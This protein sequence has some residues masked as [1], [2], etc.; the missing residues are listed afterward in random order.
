MLH[1]PLSAAEPRNHRTLYSLQVQYSPSPHKDLRWEN[2]SWKARSR[3]SWPDTVCKLPYFLA[4]TY[5]F[6]A[7]DALWTPRAF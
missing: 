1:S 6:G 2:W 3:E 7:I 5:L 4:V